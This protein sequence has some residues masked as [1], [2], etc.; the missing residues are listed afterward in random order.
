MSPVLIGR[1][2]AGRERGWSA[3]DDASARA[4][5]VL[6]Q[7][8]WRADHTAWG[9]LPM[10]QRGTSLPE[11]ELP[12][13]L[14]LPP[15]PLRRML[16][17]ELGIERQMTALAE[18]PQMGQL[19]TF[20]RTAAQMRGGED[21]LTSRLGMPRVIQHPTARIG[22]RPLA[23][24]LGSGDDRR[25]DDI[26]P[27]GGIVFYVPWQNNA[28]LGVRSCS[29]VMRTPRPPAPT[30]YTDNAPGSHDRPR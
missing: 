28:L 29:V 8:V 14:T 5:C 19:P 1:C 15:Q 23:A 10:A 24:I 21:H 18:E 6:P 11:P 4:L 3:C 20:R 16:S 22:R 25:T 9:R 2:L 7:A 12:T 26:T 17:M 27:I 30:A 13:C